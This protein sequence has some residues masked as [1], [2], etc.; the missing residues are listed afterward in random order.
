MNLIAAIYM[1]EANLLTDDLMVNSLG[2]AQPAFAWLAMIGASAVLAVTYS[3][4][5]SG[6]GGAA[7]WN[8]PVGNISACPSVRHRRSGLIVCQVLSSAFRIVVSAATN[9]ASKSLAVMSSGTKTENRA[10]FL[11]RTYLPFRKPATSHPCSFNVPIRFDHPLHG[12]SV[13]HR[14]QVIGVKPDSR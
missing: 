11:R 13:A 14:R 1:C 10:L 3:R 9:N 12:V 6:G 4:P 7:P 2:P 5:P 8:H